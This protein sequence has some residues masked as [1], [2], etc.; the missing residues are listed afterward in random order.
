MNIFL[1]LSLYSSLILPTLNLKLNKTLIYVFSLTFL[2]VISLI[3]DPLS[4]PDTFNYLP[5]IESGTGNW[6]NTISPTFGFIVNFL[7]NIVGLDTLTTLQVINL[8]PFLCIFIS[9]LILDNPIF[10]PIYLSS[11]TFSLLSFNAIRQGLAIGFLTLALSIFIKN[12]LSKKNYLQSYNFYIFIT[13]L[14]ASI[15][16]HPSSLIF[17]LIFMITFFGYKYKKTLT[18]LK[19]KKGVLIYT[20]LFLLLIITIF[21][22]QPLII[23]F[24]LRRGSIPFN[25]KYLSSINM[26]FGGNHFSSIYR[27]SIMFLVYLYNKSIVKKL[28]NPNEVIK[29]IY[30]LN[31]II[32]FTFIPIIMVTL[33][34]PPLILSRLSHF[35]IIPLFLSFYLT[36]KIYPGKRL[37]IHNLIILVGILTYTSNSVLSILVAKI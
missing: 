19:I 14:I 15:N 30:D 29:N 12:L 4:P 28:K 33:F 34:S 10:L 32:H 20:L 37:F 7:R 13:F 21:Y 23:S 6:F 3:R 26:D 25:I 16:S 36:N 17:I 31:K 24:L 22:L 2:L 9:S 8:I 27:I 35:Y 18:T 11:E 5:A 1:F